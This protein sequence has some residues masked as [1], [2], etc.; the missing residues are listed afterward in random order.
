MK[1]LVQNELIIQP[2]ITAPLAEF[3]AMGAKSDG[4]YLQKFNDSAERLLTTVDEV[5][6][7][8]VVHSHAYLPLSGGTMTSSARVV[9]LNA[10]MLD[11]YHASGFS[12]VNHTHSEYT[13]FFQRVGMTI[14][15]ATTGDLLSIDQ[16]WT[17][18]AVLSSNYISNERHGLY[19]DYS[20]G[21]IADF[22]GGGVPSY[23]YAG[24]MLKVQ[25]GTG[26][27]NF[28]GYT[29]LG[30]RVLGV[31]QYGNMKVITGLNAAPYDYWKYNSDGV[32]VNI[33]SAA[34]G[35]GTYQ[36][37]A[38]VAGNNITID[39]GSGKG[40]I[41][42]T[43]NAALN[44][45]MNPLQSNVTLT[46]AGVYYTVASITLPS[47]G[48]YMLQA[49]VVGKFTVYASTIVCKFNAGTTTYAS[50]VIS[51]IANATYNTTA[52]HTIITVGSSTTIYLSAKSTT[53]GASISASCGE[54]NT[55]TKISYVKLV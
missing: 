20:G 15:P 45:L 23:K 24:D 48:T 22:D 12:E 3:I 51:S 6:Y 11:G 39:S 26:L 10:D 49:D 44:S 41:S 42:S 31:D 40:L 52:M 14:S 55:A 54:N 37:V 17:P 33:E 46:T 18:Y 5:N 9:N 36:G 32:I 21:V 43:I 30:D 16:V 19:S 27:V 1:N 29:G 8:P 13:N 25:D 7:A 2:S 50:S 4:L 47:A 53:A 35:A 34:I 38:I 28:G